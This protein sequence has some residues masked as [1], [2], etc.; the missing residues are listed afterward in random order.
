MLV[1]RSADREQAHHT[2][3]IPDVRIWVDRGGANPAMDVKAVLE[4]KGLKGSKVGV[5]MHAWC[6]TAPALGAW[7]RARWRASAACEDATDLVQGLRLVKSPAE[8]DYVSKAGGL[9]DDAL[10]ALQRRDRARASTRA[11]SMP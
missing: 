8:L 5:E 2:S 9:A 10:A 1:T 3:V 6:L 7:S 11:T 4:E